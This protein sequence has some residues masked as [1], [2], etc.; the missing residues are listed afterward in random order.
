MTHLTLITSIKGL[1]PNAVTERH[2]LASIYE[3]GGGIIQFITSLYFWTPNLQLSEPTNILPLR[4]TRVGFS[5]LTLQYFTLL[6]IPAVP[7]Q[8]QCT[9]SVNQYLWNECSIAIFLLVPATTTS[10]ISCKPFSFL[11]PAGMYY[12]YSSCYSP[13]F[14]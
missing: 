1:S 8:T 2:L 12:C 14:R 5:R 4:A 11:C 6:P 13:F 10:Q 7:R 3:C 9:E